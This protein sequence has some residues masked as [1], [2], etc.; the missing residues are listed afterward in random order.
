MSFDE[1]K[2]RAFLRGAAEETVGS[3]ADQARVISRI[4]RYQFLVGTSAVLVMSI[5]LVGVIAI[6]N[7]FMGKENPGATSPAQR[8][9]SPDGSPQSPEPS[10]SVPDTALLTGNGRIPLGDVSLC[11]S[12][13]LGSGKSLSKTDVIEASGSVLE[14]ANAERPD[15]SRLWSLLDPSLQSAY[16]TEEQFHQRIYAASLDDAFRKWGISDDV[17]L[18]SGPILGELIADTCGEDVAEAL[19]VGQA[20]FPRFDGVSGGAAQL[21]FVVRDS[22]PRFWLLD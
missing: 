19:V 11:P 3:G 7:S 21:Y 9:Q 16:G 20:F 2:L 13:D 8:T 22:T 18:D 12:G 14:A 17:W 5:A 4:R 1:R 6:G 15:T 10:S